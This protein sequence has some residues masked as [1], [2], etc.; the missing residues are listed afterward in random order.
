MTSEIRIAEGSDATEVARR[1][2]EHTPK[3]LAFLVLVALSRA[4]CAGDCPISD[5]PLDLP[6][7]QATLVQVLQPAATVVTRVVPTRPR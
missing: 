6:Q 7:G 1:P 4:G 3:L 5:W 2:L